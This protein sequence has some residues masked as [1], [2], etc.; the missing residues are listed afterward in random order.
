MAELGPNINLLFKKRQ[1]PILLQASLV[2]EELMIFYTFIKK[3]T[4][5]KQTNPQPHNPSENKSI[6][7]T[8]LLKDSE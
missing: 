7:E 4:P 5:N 8:D 2:L 6:T 3:K 1:K